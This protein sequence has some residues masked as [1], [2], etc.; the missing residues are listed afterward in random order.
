[1]S[2]LSEPQLSPPHSLLVMIATAPFAVAGGTVIGGIGSGLFPDVVTT[3]HSISYIIF[4]VGAVLV[5]V[6]VSIAFERL[7]QRSAAWLR[8]TTALEY[9]AIGLWLVY[10]TMSR[11]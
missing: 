9:A 2:D 7:G 6:P 3:W 4:I 8:G 11:P 5:A 10:L 1:M